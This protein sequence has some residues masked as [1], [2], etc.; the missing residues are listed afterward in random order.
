MERLAPAGTIGT[1]ESGKGDYFG[2]LVVAGVCV[3][4]GGREG[5]AALGVR[6]SKTLS[7]RQA[8]RLARAVRQAY[9]IAGVAIGPRGHHALYAQGGHPNRLLAWAHAPGI[10]NPA[11]R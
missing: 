2:P 7:D 9:P 1:D 10:R 5:L 8:E 3:P 4:A 6:D 11:E